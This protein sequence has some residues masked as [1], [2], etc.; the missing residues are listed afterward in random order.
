MAD[1]PS[2][3]I[4]AR[5]RTQRTSYCLPEPTSDSMSVSR[6]TQN[7]TYLRTFDYNTLDAVPNYQHYANTQVPGEEKRARPSLVDLHCN[8]MEIRQ[9]PSPVNEIRPDDELGKERLG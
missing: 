7:N 2:V 5:R 8:M 4:L 3:P 9:H 1:S 6:L